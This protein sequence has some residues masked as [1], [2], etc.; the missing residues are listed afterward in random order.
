MLLKRSRSVL[1]HG[2]SG[3]E[4]YLGIDEPIV[5]SNQ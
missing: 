1:G 5:L 2:N 4:F 3:W